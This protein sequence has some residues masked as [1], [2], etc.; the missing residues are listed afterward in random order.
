MYD[1]ERKGLVTVEQ[2]PKMINCRLKADDKDLQEMLA[3]ASDK[4]ARI[5]EL[6]RKG[7]EAEAQPKVKEIKA[8][9]KS[10][11]YYQGD[12]K[13]AKPLILVP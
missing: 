4:T 5:K 11:T 9:S 3:K 8:P 10:Y 7:L 6:I 12:I 1:N 2:L 13:V